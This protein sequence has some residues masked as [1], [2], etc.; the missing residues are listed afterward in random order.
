MTI[1]L[2]SLNLLYQVIQ[3]VILIDTPLLY[4]FDSTVQ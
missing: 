2:S 4:I 1:S 3:A